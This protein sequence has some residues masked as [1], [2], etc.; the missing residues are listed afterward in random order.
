MRRITTLAAALPAALLVAA[1][2]L[3][4]LALAHEHRDIGG[5]KY[6][7]VVGWDTEPAIAGQMNGAGFR[8]SSK[9]DNQPVTGLDKTLKLTLAFGGGTPQAFQLRAVLDQP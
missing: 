4:G 9:A 6:T 3:P 8:I 2:L 1:L 5:G 7:A